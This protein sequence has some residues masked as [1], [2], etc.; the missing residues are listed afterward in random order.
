MIPRRAHF[1]L[2]LGLAFTL[3]S[4]LT[5][6]GF[7]VPD[8]LGQESPALDTKSTV[9]EGQIAPRLQNL[10][11]HKHP[12]LQGRTKSVSSRGQTQDADR[13]KTLPVERSLPNLLCKR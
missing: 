2:G 12:A 1:S 9:V 11:D 10:G 6:C 3:C 5:I 4:T 8:A 13:G 7:G